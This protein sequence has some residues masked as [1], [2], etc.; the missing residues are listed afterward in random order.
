MRTWSPTPT[1][2]ELP[3]GA[4]MRE[5]GGVCTRSSARSAAGSEAMTCAGTVGPPA[6]STVISSI[7][8]TTW[9]AVITSPSTETTTP[10]PTSVMA[11]S[12]R[13]LT[14]T[15]RPRPR[16]TTTLGLTLA[17]TPRTS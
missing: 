9:A 7:A 6:N 1:V 3:S 14:P 5:R 16:M 11:V 8:C 12:P 15:S 2:S 17:K 13:P 10:E 4:A